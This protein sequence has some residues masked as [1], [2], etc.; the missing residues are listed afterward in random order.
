M[1]ACHPWGAR[2][3]HC[4][5]LAQ[6]L[7]DAHVDGALMRIEGYA[8]AVCGFGHCANLKPHGLSEF[9]VGNQYSGEPSG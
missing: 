6:V 5:I 2:F 3:L 7:N 8:K 4:R 9:F 1:L